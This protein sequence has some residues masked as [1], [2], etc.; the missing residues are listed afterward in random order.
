MKRADLTGHVSGRLTAVRYI[1][2][3]KARA[4][5][6]CQCTCGNE[7]LVAA[8][9][10]RHSARSPVLSC[11]CLRVEK[12]GKM[13]S[14]MRTHGEAAERTAEYIAWRNIQN[15]C[16]NPNAENWKYY[17]AMGVTVCERWRAAF[18]NFL[19]DMGRR[20]SD[21]HSIDRYPNP[22][23]NYEP[24][25]CRWATAFQQRHNRRGASRERSTTAAD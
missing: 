24:T 15:R 13:G 5:W 4:Y 2:T 6:L 8:C 22:Y 11:G 12:A 7:T 20:P 10:L 21:Q 17:G 16:Y 14:S 3:R 1:E 19:A 25:N 9:N 23:G 18:E